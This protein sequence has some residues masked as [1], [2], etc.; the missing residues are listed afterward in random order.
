MAEIIVTVDGVS[1]ADHVE[2][3]MLLVHYLREVVGKTGTPIGC[4]TSN[5][6]ACTVL[7]DGESV[8]VEIVAD[9]GGTRLTH[10]R[11]VGLKPL[12][13]LRQLRGELLLS[14][15]LALLPLTVL[16]PDRAP[17][18]ALGPR[19]VHGDPAL[20]LDHLTTA[21]SCGASGATREDGR[22][23]SRLRPSGGPRGALAER[24]WGICGDLGPYRR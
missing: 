24:L 10:V 5:C 20:E 15:R 18:A 4:D 22:T 23:T 1:Y 13:D 6:G 19:R 16:V 17:P 11:R 7:M 9:E 2:P 3:R 8:R 12:R 14:R 21:S